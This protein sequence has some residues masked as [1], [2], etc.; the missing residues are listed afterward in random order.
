M[1]QNIMKAHRNPIQA[2]AQKVYNHFRRAELRWVKF[3]PLSI[4]LLRAEVETGLSR[5]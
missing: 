1:L 5:M 3:Y 2:V 4:M